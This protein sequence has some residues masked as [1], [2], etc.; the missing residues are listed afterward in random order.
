[1]TVEIAE[2]IAKSPYLYHVTYRN[3]LDRIRRLQMLES[4]A[5][6]MEQAGQLDSLR[7]RRDE[8]KPIVIGTDTICLTDQGPIIEANISFEGNWTLAD[9][10]EAI[11]RR[12]FFWR[13]LET[14]LL[15]ADTGQS[16]KYSAK[17]H[18][19]VFLRAKLKQ[20]IQ[21]N[22]E[23]GPELCKY[24]SGAARKVKGI[25]SPRGPGTFVRPE[26]AMFKVDD[27]REVVFRDHVKLPATTEWC[28]KHC[29]GPWQ[30]LF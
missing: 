26:V 1:M 17:G 2:L 4:A 28:E 21:I 8:M 25:G 6:L 13:G 12:V 7:S 30:R 11:N 27:V 3:S 16:E 9:L 14:G 19:L 18:S 10:I 15:R 24:N 29:Q 22:A 23:R 20:T 5:S